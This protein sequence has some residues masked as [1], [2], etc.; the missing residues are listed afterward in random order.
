RF[1]LH[2][3]RDLSSFDSCG[4]NLVLSL[5]VLQHITSADAK[6][7]YVQEFVRVLRPGGLLAL[8]LPSRIPGWHRIQLRPRL[9]RLLRRAGV[10]RGRLYR[11]LHL[12]P[13]RMSSLPRTR[14]VG[15]IRAAGGQMLD[16]RDE[17][18]SGGVI[19]THYLATKDR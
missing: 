7:R 19:S 15:L 10:S 8:Q 18:Q 16:M 5:L 1:D 13:M 6:A 4:F 11:Q 3:G 14:V 12:H 9:Y 2:D 17:M